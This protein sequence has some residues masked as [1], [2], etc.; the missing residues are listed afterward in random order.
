[1]KKLP[2]GIDGFEKIRDNDFY[3]VDKTGFIVEL[4]RNWGEV[5]L[6]SARTKPCSTASKSRRKK[7]CASSTRGSSR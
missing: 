1:M 3:Y 4:L 7:S 5:N 6:R 2:I